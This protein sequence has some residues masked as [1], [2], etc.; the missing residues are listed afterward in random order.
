M[1][2]VLGCP[3]FG[4]SGPRWKKSC[5]RPHMK[6]TNTLKTQKPH[7][8][9]SKFMILC[10]ATFIAILGHIW[11]QAVGWTP[12]ETHN[13][14]N[15]IS[16]VRSTTS[17]SPC[18]QSYLMVVHSK[19]SRSQ[20]PQGPSAH[21]QVQKE[22]LITFERVMKPVRHAKKIHTNLS[23]AVFA[24]GILIPSGVNGHSLQTL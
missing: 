10:W 17:A 14:R 19:Y 8:I 9:V 1:S 22:N 23:L 2:T 18:K 21:K 24:R 15:C 7:N 16:L 6:Y 4:I 3:N 11:P 13:A 20:R 12:L 5:L